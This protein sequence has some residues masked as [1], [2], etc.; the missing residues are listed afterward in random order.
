MTSAGHDRPIAG[1]D[2][3]NEMAAI[4]RADNRSAQRHDPVG[5]LADRE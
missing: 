5:A 4:R 1:T 2:L 3:G